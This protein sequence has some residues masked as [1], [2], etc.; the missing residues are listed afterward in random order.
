MKKSM[1]EGYPEEQFTLLRVIMHPFGELA[2]NHSGF[3]MSPVSMEIFPAQNRRAVQH[4]T[5]S[6]L[7][8]F[9]ATRDVFSDYWFRD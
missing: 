2:G 8:S 9:I 4:G 1:F 5:A 3:L 7:D 6:S